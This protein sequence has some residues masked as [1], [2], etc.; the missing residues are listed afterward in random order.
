MSGHQAVYPPSTGRDRPTVGSLAI[1]VSIEAGQTAFTRTPLAIRSLA[2]E[3]VNPSKAA[4]EALSAG[5]PGGAFSRVG[6]VADDCPHVTGI[7]LVSE[8]FLHPG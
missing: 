2:S 7:H 5:I 4:F 6:D 3:R 8:R 1:G